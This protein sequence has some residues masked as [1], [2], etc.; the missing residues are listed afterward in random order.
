VP[1]KMGII[2]KDLLIMRQRVFDVSAE[3][4]PTVLYLLQTSS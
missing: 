4:Q 2:L 1:V 3:K